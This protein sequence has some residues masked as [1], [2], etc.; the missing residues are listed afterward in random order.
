[1]DSVLAVVQSISLSPLLERRQIET[2]VVSLR[3]QLIGPL[4]GFVVL[5]E[6]PGRR[7][8]K[9]VRFYVIGESLRMR[10]GRWRRPTSFLMRIGG[11]KSRTSVR[12]VL[13]R[14]QSNRFQGESGR[15]RRTFA[16][17]CRHFLRRGRS[18][19]V[20]LI[21]EIL[22]GADPE[23]VSAFVRWVESADQ[24]G[25]WEYNPPLQINDGGD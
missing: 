16:S 14:G 15:R 2:D 20:S 1:M 5:V 9:N 23:V 24:S 11:S 17:L 7:E 4:V 18:R 10:T 3:H 25:K 19:F 22:A 21:I 12:S 6:S 13:K 8:L